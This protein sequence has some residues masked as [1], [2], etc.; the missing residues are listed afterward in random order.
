MNREYYVIQ[1]STTFFKENLPILINESRISIFSELIKESD[2]CK[3]RGTKFQNHADFLL[4]KNDNYNGITEQA[5]DRLGPLIE[6]ITNSDAEIYIHN[7]PSNVL[8]YLKEKEK[9]DEI[10]LSIKKQKYDLDRDEQNF[11][12]RM[13]EISSSIIGQNKAIIE[14]SKSM[15]Y[16]TN[17]KREKPY[18]VM[19]YGNSSLGKTQ[20]VREIADKFYSNQFFEKHLSMF[21]NDS[22]SDYFFGNKPNRASL[23]YELLARTSNLIFLD[24]LDKCPEYFFSAF[25]TLFDNKIFRDSTY[26]V[27]T[28]GTLIIL[29]SNYLSEAEMKSKLGLPIFYRIDKFI[30]FNDFDTETIYQVVL[31]EIKDREDEYGHLLNL[32]D[33]YSEVSKQINVTGENARTIKYKIQKVIE[34][35]LFSKINEEFHGKINK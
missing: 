25:Y 10:V 31:K 32:D 29:T 6:D 4:I 19:F 12:H 5:H 33:I 2:D 35:L 3:V 1:G 8:D 17:V 20:L 30:E 22:Y 7:P 13:E 11:V 28:A 26:E 27:N 15:W 14:V 9:N 16:L 23:G 24:E 18:V 21:K 34:D